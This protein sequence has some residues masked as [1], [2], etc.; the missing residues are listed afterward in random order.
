MCSSDLAVEVAINPPA[1]EDLAI[2]N[3]ALGDDAGL[4]GSALLALT[5]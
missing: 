5:P 2:E 4:V 3:A 1:R